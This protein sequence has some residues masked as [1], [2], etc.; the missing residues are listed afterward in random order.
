MSPRFVIRLDDVCPGLKW[1]AMERAQ[2]VFEAN[3]IKPLLGVVPDNRDP[4]LDVSP[5]RGDFWPWLRERA[6]AGWTIAQHGYQHVYG[7]KDAGCLKINRRSEFAGL[8]YDEQREKL[9]LGRELL[10]AQGLP[11]DVFMAP[12]HSFDALTLK[13]LKELGFT[14]VTDGFGLYP[15]ERDGLTFV[16]QLFATPRHF[17]FGVYTVCLHLNEMSD[18]SLAALEDF[19]RRRRGD[20]V[21]FP[22]AAA[23]RGP[24]LVNGPAGWILGRGLRLAR[25]LRPARPR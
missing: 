10:G 23:L 6:K 25:R 3:G 4:Q 17:G 9:R 8:P 20:L 5:P 13:A 19:C 1:S 11:T 14:T 21:D 7:T 15:F 24:G 2:R 18:R 12:A 22:R 16:P